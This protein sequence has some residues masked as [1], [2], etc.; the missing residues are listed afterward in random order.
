MLARSG[1]LIGLIAVL[2]A[3]AFF[4]WRGSDDLVSDNEGGTAAI[5]GSFTLQDQK[6]N[7]V[8]D[9]D[10]RGKWSLVFFGFTSCPDICPMGLS[11]IDNTLQQLGSQASKIQPVFITLDSA[12]DTPEVLASYLSHFN[13]PWLGLTGTSI[14]VDA[15][16]GAYRVYYA[17]QDL[18]ESELGYTINH[19]GYI[20]LMGPD[21]KYRAHFN[22]NDAPEIIAA[23]VQK[24]LADE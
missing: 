11:A 7:T 22:H 16:A 4:I 2:V 8:S 24:A 3:A 23:G 18:P 19:S 9:K 1:L 12:H 21:G 15:A 20:Y 17:R 13:S 6:G 5:G 10:L 14:Q